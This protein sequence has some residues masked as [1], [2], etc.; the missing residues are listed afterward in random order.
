M[1]K[2]TFLVFLAAAFTISFFSFKGDDISTTPRKQKVVKTIVID[3]GHRG[4]HAGAKGQ[5]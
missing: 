5:Y 4:R 1:I 2:R 3:P